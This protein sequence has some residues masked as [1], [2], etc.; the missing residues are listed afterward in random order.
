MAKVRKAAAIRTGTRF[1]HMYASCPTGWGSPSADAVKVARAA[2]Q[3]GI[4]PLYEVEDGLRYT[5]REREGR[6]VAEYAALQ[7]RFRHLDGEGLATLQ[8][9]VDANWDRLHKLASI[10]G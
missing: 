1:I 6:P 5:L 7:S 8:S 10:G 2:V 4:F 3:C 9:R